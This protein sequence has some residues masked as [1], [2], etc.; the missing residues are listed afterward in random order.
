MNIAS[1]SFDLATATT[2]GVL[3]LAGYNSNKGVVGAISQGLKY[4]SIASVID[5]LA[6]AIFLENAKAQEL[7]FT[8]G[9][10]SA[11]KE[12]VLY[13]G[14][15][16]TESKLLLIPR[17]ATSL[18]LGMTATRGITAHAETEKIGTDTK[19]GL[20]W[21]VSREL[22]LQ[23]L[24][25]TY[26]TYTLTLADSVVFA[27]SEVCP[28]QSSD[29][30]LK[31]YSSAWFYKLLSSFGFRITANIASQSGISAALIQHIVFNTSQTLANR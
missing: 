17:L 15:L 5:R 28:K 27:L 12:E 20:I 31:Q 19:I 3:H 21:T 16:Q 8:D 26:A 2:A 14:I 30:N 11:L 29:K 1:L 13:S 18:I 9:I 25:L 24:P 4:F 6:G 7:S 10:K 22:L 23:Y